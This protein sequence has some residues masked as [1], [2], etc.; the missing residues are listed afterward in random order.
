MPE[1]T[2]TQELTDIEMNLMAQLEQVEWPPI[3]PTLVEAL[4][5]WLSPQFRQIF[6]P[7]INTPDQAL[8]VISEFKG[9]MIILNKLN[10]VSKAQRKEALG[11]TRTSLA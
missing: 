2:D 8:A 10:A 6:H 5:R 1:K 3:D 11:G 9:S 7:R 4:E